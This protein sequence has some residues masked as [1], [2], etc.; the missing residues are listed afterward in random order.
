LPFYERVVAFGRAHDICIAHDSAYAET[1]FAGPPPRIMQVDGAKDVCIEFHSLSKGFNMTGWRIGF[2]VGHPEV[3]ASL[4]AVKDN[5]DSGP[6]TAIQAAAAEALRG[7]GRPEVEA[8]RELYRRRRDIL[9]R[10]LRKAG[11]PVTQPDATFFVWA[12][13]PQ[14]HD[15]NEVA[16][17]LLDEADV[18]VVPGYG[19]GETARGFVRFALTVEEVRTAEAVERIAK[20]QW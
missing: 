15:S 17:R 18:V 8:Q 5:L 2:A 3:I 13:C 16:M 9:F 19:F 14:G 1:Y 4:A 6:F 11:W 7:Y 20:I 10:G 12:K